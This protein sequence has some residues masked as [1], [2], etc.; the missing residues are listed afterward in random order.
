MRRD[1]RCSAE[2]EV[3]R[4]V[5]APGLVCGARAVRLLDGDLLTDVGERRL[6]RG[7]TAQVEEPQLPD[8]VDP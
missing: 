6:E 2:R 1:S 4:Q 7:A 8:F 3:Q 5:V